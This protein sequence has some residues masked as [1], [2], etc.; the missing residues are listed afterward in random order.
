MGQPPRAAPCVRRLKRG[1]VDCQGQMLFPKAS[2][3]KVFKG[4]G[5]ACNV[6][7]GGQEISP[8]CGPGGKGMKIM[9]GLQE[10]GAGRGQADS[11]EERGPGVA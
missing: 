8:A 10:D 4:K 1:C 7:S 9:G 11:E 5:E 2:F 3:P 6:G